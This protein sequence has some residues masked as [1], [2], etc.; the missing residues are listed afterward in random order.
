MTFRFI[1]MIIVQSQLKKV[2]FM[3]SS[4]VII[5]L[6]LVMMLWASAFVGIR[7]GLLEYAPGPLALLR[8]LVASLCVLVIY[9]RL[10]GKTKMPMSVRIQL[11]AIGVLG[12]GVYNICLNIGEMTVTAGVASFVIGLMPIITILLSVVFLH[13]R[14]GFLVWAG[15]L[16][17]IVG[18]FILMFAEKDGNV[19]S[20]GVLLILLSAVMGSLY[21]LLQKRYLGHYHPI[22]ITAWVIWGGTLM[23]LWF[24]PE[25]C[26]QLP[27]ASWRASLSAVYMGI[28]PGAVAYVGWSYVLNHMKASEASLYLYFMPIISTVFGFLLL[29]EQPAILSLVGGSLA[30]IG[31]L[32]ATRKLAWL[33][34][35]VR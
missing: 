4:K 13:E 19:V 15:V 9:L 12:I 34:K 2:I 25:L 6:A 32:V 31:A 1:S 17:S 8:F 14:P 33:Q 7:V 21:T 16:I 27:M 23:L 11:M 26:Q 24:L 35:P 20:T 5:T 29:D 10:P 22:A 28:F 3:N 18:M 30:L